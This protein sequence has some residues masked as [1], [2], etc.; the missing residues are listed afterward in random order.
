MHKAVCAPLLTV[1]CLATH[2][3]C[4]HVMWSCRGEG[5]GR[6]VSGEKVAV[7]LSALLTPDEMPRD[8]ALRSPHSPRMS[9]DAAR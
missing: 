6:A 5:A 2:E 7:A 9:P 1:S 4:A 8:S 3:T